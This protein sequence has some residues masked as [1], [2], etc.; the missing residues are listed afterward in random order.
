MMEIRPILELGNSIDELN[1]KLAEA[2][3]ESANPLTQKNSS[4]SN[5]AFTRT[6]R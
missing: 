1:R 4:R 5:G 3:S 6:N 2:E